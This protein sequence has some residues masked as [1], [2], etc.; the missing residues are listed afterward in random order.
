MKLHI[1]T[2]CS[3]LIV[4][5]GV[6]SLQSV[7]EKQPRTMPLVPMMRLLLTDM[8]KIDEGMYTEDY[9]KIEEG[10]R[11][12]AG[13]PV[14]TDE[15]KQLVKKTLGDRMGRFVDFDMKVHHHA[16]SIAAAAGNRDMGEVLRHYRI[17][18]QGCIDCHSAFRSEII[19]A[20]N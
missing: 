19:N 15:D 14:M 8:Y 1:T 18:Q 16:D 11:S 13:H 6:M 7:G 12:I 20:R 4:T 3:L 17:L 2:L 10:A 5:L 9:R